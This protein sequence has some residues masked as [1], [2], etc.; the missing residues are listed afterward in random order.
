MSDL[1]WSLDNS[2]D[3][4]FLPTNTFDLTPY[5]APDIE[6]KP[7]KLWQKMYFVK[8]KTCIVFA[9]IN[10]QIL[11]FLSVFR[12][13]FEKYDKISMLDIHN[14]LKAY[15]LNT[16]FF[17]SA[18][19]ITHVEHLESDN[20][21][22]GQF[23]WPVETHVVDPTTLEVVDGYWNILKHP[24]YDTVSAFGTGV[25]GYLN[26]INQPVKFTSRFAENEFMRAIQTNAILIVQILTKE[27][28]STY[29]L[30]DNWGGGF[31]LAF[32]NGRHFEKIDKMAYVINQSQYETNGNLG[33]PIPRLIM[34]YK[35]VNDILYILSLEVYKYKITETDRHIV[36][37]SINGEYH[38]TV[39]E[40]EGIDIE[41]ILD[42]DLP[43]KYS[44]TTENI[45]MGYSFLTKDG[46]HFNP[47]FY[48]LGPEVRIDF[49]QG[50]KL[51]VF[52]DKII[53]EEII[54][55]SKKI[56]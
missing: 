23:Y 43:T 30:R 4:I 13:T 1:L 11:V 2:K 27:R 29:T 21:H 34:Y 18:F 42:F 53:N 37:T 39:Y 8:D 56:F 32:Y 28:E 51:Q 54:N 25:E 47:A 10:N 55:S 3:P 46:G 5:L 16:N 26:L 14:F 24:N 19:F 35:Y 33:L 45:A 22:I 41:N 12:K 49:V 50:E 31:E 52:V 36:Y 9:G 7:F 17:D 6:E 15:D 44:F 20:I 38:P 40:I 48:N